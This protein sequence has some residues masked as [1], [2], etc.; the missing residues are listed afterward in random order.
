M[1]VP[2]SGRMWR[3]IS[4]VLLIAASASYWWYVQREAPYGG[5]TMGVAYGIAGTLLIL[6]LA[7]FGVRKRAYRSRV[8]T[9]EGWL[10]SHI[11]LGLLVVVVLLF[12]SGGHFSDRIAATSFV[13]LAIVVV[14]GIFG[15]VL[16]AAIP[17][18]LTSVEGNLTPTQISTQINRLGKQMSAIA[19]DRSPEFQSLHDELLRASTPSLLAGWRILFLSRTERLEKKDSPWTKLLARVPAEEQEELRQMLV[20]SRQRNELLRTLVLQ[21]RYRNLLQSWRY[22]HIPL[23]FALFIFMVVHIVAAFYYGRLL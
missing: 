9:L 5:S 1:P 12:H 20:L 6:L 15:A 13:V 18:Q 23:T 11:Y 16:Y 19:A 8:G 21:Q 7:L 10:Q 3:R 2:S 14:S 22:V 4:V 17:R